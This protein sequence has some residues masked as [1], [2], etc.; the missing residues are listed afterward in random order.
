MAEMYRK[1]TMRRKRAAAA[2]IAGILVVAA[3]GGDPPADVGTPQPPPPAEPSAPAPEPPAES[4]PDPPPEPPT[5]TPAPSPPPES[6]PEPP[7]EPESPPE[8]PPEPESPPAE[9]LEIQVDGGT[10]WQ[11]VFSAVSA[12]EQ[13]CIRGALSDELDSLLGERVMAIGDTEEWVVSFFGCLTPENARSVFLAA[14]VAGLR[15]DFG[16]GELSDEEWS[17][18]RDRVADLDVTALV[19]ADVAGD[20]DLEFVEAA[21]VLFG[22]LPDVFLAEMLAELG[23]DPDELSEDELSCLREWVSATDW[24]ALMSSEADGDLDAFGDLFDLLSCVPGVFDLPDLEPAGPDDHADSAGG[25]T[26]VTVGEPAEG[27]LDHLGDVDFFTFE[28]V[29]GESYR[30]EVTLGSLEDSVMFLYDADGSLLADNDDAAGSLASLIT[31]MA[32]ASGSYYVE[33]ASFDSFGIG[34]YT[35]SLEPAGPDDHADSAGGATPVTVGEPAQGAMDHFGDVDFFTFEA[36]AGESYRIQVTL[37]TL[38]D[39]EL[40]LYDADGSELAYNDDD[41]GSLASLITW[42]APGSGSYH[43]EVGALGA[44]GTGSYTLSVTTP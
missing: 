32:P 5:E 23:V 25:A 42:V 24:A 12:A 19:A 31:W 20:A 40:A 44:S 6:A 21:A 30:I 26:P 38:E 41:E 33:V 15:E 2:V 36:V 27:G 35:L 7:P 43:V 34:S 17:C 14:V 22:C 13:D 16:T 1:P 9:R 39:S 8:P 4:P 28:A 29:A 37:G 10:A 11:E 3:C 18:L